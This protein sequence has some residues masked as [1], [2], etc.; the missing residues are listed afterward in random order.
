MMEVRRII[1]VLA[2]L[3]VCVLLSTA[4]SA[5]ARNDT[6]KLTPEQYDKE[7]RKGQKKTNEKYKSKTIELTGKVLHVYRH[8]SGKPMIDLM[9]ANE[10]SGIHC[11]TVEKAPWASFA[12]GQTVKVTGKFPEYPVVPQLD[13]CSVEAVTPSRIRSV[14]AEALARECETDPVGTSKK[15]DK[16]TI[17]VSGTVV[18]REFNTKT[19][20]TSVILKGTGK[21]QVECLLIPAEKEVGAAL[22]VGQSV[23]MVGQFGGTFDKQVHLSDADVV[24]EQK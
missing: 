7:F 5:Q 14:A 23:T 2:L 9:A 10:F 12:P 3:I 16:Q 22:Q 20:F 19:N 17:K 6:V 15:M 21:T 24:T 1:R 11:F 4:V 18:S 13:D 8:F